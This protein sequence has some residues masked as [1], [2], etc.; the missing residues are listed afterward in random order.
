MTY[1]QFL[2][3]FL[4]LPLALMTWVMRR[5]VERRQAIVILA[6]SLVALIYTTPW[7]NYLVA[8]RIW[9]YNPELVTGITL[10]WVPLE[11]YLFFILQPALAGL[12]LLGLNRRAGVEMAPSPDRPP[13]RWIGTLAV[14]LIWAGAVALLI[15]GW[16]PA[17]YLAL[18]LIWFLPPIAFQMAFGAD[19]VWH[20]RRQVWGALLSLVI[21]FCLADVLAIR[22]GTWAINPEF[23]LGMIG[24]WLPLEEMVFFLLTNTVVVLGITLMLAPESHRRARRWIKAAPAAGRGI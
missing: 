13:I 2:I 1:G 16:K 7:D 17:T 11:E 24:G 9:W 20:R 6:H 23:S 3:L 15:S 22:A 19:I 12:W 14:G 18:E 10:G 21:Y 5:R 4:G 8:T